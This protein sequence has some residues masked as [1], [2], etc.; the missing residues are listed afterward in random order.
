MR[1]R[2]AFTLVELLV[3]IAIIGILI[4]LLLPAV[5]AAR[6]AARRMSC[7]NNMK[8][9]GLGVHNY[10]STY[11]GLLP[12][13]NARTDVQGLFTYLLPY[14]EYGALFDQANL[15]ANVLKDSE[16]NMRYES[17]P[18]YLCPTYAGP[19]IIR[20]HSNSYCNGALT[21]YQGIAGTLREGDPIVASP[22]GDMPQNGVFQW[23]KQVSIRDITDGTINTL[24]FAEFVHRDWTAHARFA[25]YP[26][27]VRSWSLGTVY[28][29]NAKRP[30]TYMAKVLEYAVNQRLD[31]YVDGVQFNHLPMGSEHPGGAQFALTDGSVTFIIEDT[32]I[33]ILKSMATIAGGE[34]LEE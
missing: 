15:E 9:M 18:T 6:E 13:Q 30:G 7:S 27:C 8:Q 33:D 23:L 1:T 20:N 4:A 10:A 31:R 19:T 29:T 5:Q 25:D 14:I 11:G 3:V 2:K 16:N 28:T 24:M 34:I 26:G 21:T 22:E 17:V 12:Y 32:P